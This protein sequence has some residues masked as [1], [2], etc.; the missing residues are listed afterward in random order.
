MPGPEVINVVGSLG[1]I[2]D[3]LSRIISVPWGKTI[4]C[5]VR[6]WKLGADSNNRTEEDSR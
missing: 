5:G 6:D 1:T 3:T 2:K 4:L